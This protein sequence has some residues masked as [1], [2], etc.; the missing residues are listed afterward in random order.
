MRPGDLVRFISTGEYGIVLDRE[1]DGNM[2]LFC[3]VMTSNSGYRYAFWDELE[4][5]DEAG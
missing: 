3:S 1:L 5:I 4:I 2:Q